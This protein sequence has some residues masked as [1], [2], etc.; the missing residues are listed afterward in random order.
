MPCFFIAIL[1]L[2][3]LLA[4]L[5]YFDAMAEISETR[6]IKRYSS[7]EAF[8]NDFARKDKEY[9]EW[10]KA[11]SDQLSVL[12]KKARTGDLIAHQDYLATRFYIE[13]TKENI[14]SER[15]R[16]WKLAHIHLK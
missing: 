13:E 15:N 3:A 14:E 4:P 12:E 9:A 6:E 16:M 11:A 7:L 2:L 5:I 8:K 10:Y 1:L